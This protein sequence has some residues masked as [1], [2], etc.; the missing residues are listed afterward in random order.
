M[1]IRVE[2]KT[3]ISNLLESLDGAGSDSAFGL[4]PVLQLRNI[5]V[6]LGGPDEIAEFV[7]VLKKKLGASVTDQLLQI[8]SNDP[9]IQTWLAK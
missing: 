8:L 6:S 7:A 2:W 9:G 4:G 3:A 5:A 1:G